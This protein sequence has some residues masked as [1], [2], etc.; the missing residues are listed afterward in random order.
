MGREK[1][2]MKTMK[3]KGKNTDLKI[4]HTFVYVK[5]QEAFLFNKSKTRILQN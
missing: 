2:K 3:Q 4:I 1:A 5:G